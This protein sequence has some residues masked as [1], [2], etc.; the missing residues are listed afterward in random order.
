M[1]LTG[2]L[3]VLFSVSPLHNQPERIEQGAG[4][5]IFKL[6]LESDLTKEVYLQRALWTTQY[7]PGFDIPGKR[8]RK[9]PK[10]DA[11]INLPIYAKYAKLR[12]D[13]VP[14]QKVLFELHEPQNRAHIKTLKDLL[15]SALESEGLKDQYT[16]FAYQDIIDNTANV[17]SMKLLQAS[18]V[19]T[20]STDLMLN[21]FRP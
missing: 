20:E 5:Y 14:M 1:G 18:S 11:L 7:V 15:Q 21:S 13:Q 8:A 6:T 3:E 2:F 19:L 12:L 16:I 9:L 17:S 10:T 4:D